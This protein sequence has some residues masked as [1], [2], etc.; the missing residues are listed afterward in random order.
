MSEVT[1]RL[2]STLI[3]LRQAPGG[4]LQTLMV[5]RNSRASFAGGALVFPGGALEQGDRDVAG[6]MAVGWPHLAVEEIALRIA[7]VRETFE[8][9]GILLA[10]RDNGSPVDPGTASRL[11]ELSRRD[12]AFDFFGMLRADGLRPGIDALVPFAR[13]I[14]P[15]IRPKRFDTHFFLAVAPEGQQVVPDFT[16]TTEAL[17]I[18]PKAASGGSADRPFKLVFPTRMNLSRLA[19]GASIDEIVRA[20][21]ATAIVPVMPE[22]IETADGIFIRIPEEAGYPGS[23]FPATDPATM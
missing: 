12:P 3:V 17:W 20:A 18:N 22:Y 8:E 7:A 14:T 9:S 11:L 19:G 16:E 2:A 13:W 15:P 23:L 6:E 4:L 10:C 21:R 5:V 1:P